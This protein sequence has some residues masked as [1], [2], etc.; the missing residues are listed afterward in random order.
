MELY[1]RES[2]LWSQNQKL[3]LYITSI[4]SKPKAHNVNDI[5]SF[6]FWGY[7]G[8]MPLETTDHF[9]TL[10][11]CDKYF[12]SWPT[13]GGISEIFL[14]RRVHRLKI[15][16]PIFLLTWRFLN[17]MSWTDFCGI[18]GERIIWSSAC[19]QV[20]VVHISMVNNVNFYCSFNL[21]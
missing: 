7:R 4:S 13:K 1:Q 5:V 16:L 14:Y 8:D 21:F 18:L 15:N 17:G 3:T 19:L 11:V 12:F 10:K 20:S 9:W 6:L 2:L